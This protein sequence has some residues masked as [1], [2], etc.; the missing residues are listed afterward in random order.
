ML[1]VL[2]LVKRVT[3]ELLDFTSGP[4]TEEGRPLSID[5]VRPM[6]WLLATLMKTGLMASDVPME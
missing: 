3:A 1:L 6:L 5:R 2:Q 4:S